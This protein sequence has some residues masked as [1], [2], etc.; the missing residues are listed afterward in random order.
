MALGECKDLVCQFFEF[1]F[2]Y[3]AQ[4]TEEIPIYLIINFVT[5]KNNAIE[6]VT[7]L[8]FFEMPKVGDIGIKGLSKE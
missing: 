6:A 7:A 2:D 5:L 4:Y 3:R 1:K 8:D